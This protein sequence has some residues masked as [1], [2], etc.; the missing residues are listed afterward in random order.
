MVNAMS[1]CTNP[2]E[3]AQVQKE[4]RKLV[5]RAIEEETLW[6]T[7]WTKH[8][9]P[10]TDDETSSRVRKRKSRWGSGGDGSS[11]DAA[12]AANDDDPFVRLARQSAT[13]SSGYDES[14]VYDGASDGT[15]SRSVSPLMWFDSTGKSTRKMMTKKKKKKKKKR[16]QKGKGEKRGKEEG[17]PNLLPV[18]FL[19]A[20]ERARKRQRLQRF[21]ATQGSAHHQSN[22][23]ARR[24]NPQQPVVGTCQRLEKKYFRL[25][26]AVRPC[27]VRPVS[28]LRE[29]LKMVLRKIKEGCD[30]LYACEQFKSMR[31]DL[32][33]QHVQNAFTVE[34]YETHA[35]VAIENS[36][37]NEFNQCQTQLIILYDQGIPSV[38]K[39]EFAAYRILYH[40][41]NSRTISIAQEFRSLIMDRSVCDSSSAVALA[42][43]VRRAVAL[44]DHRAFFK[45]KADAVEISKSGVAKSFASFYA[46]FLPAFRCRAILTMLRAYKPTL[47]IEYVKRELRFGGDVGPSFEAWSESVGIV[48]TDDDRRSIDVRKSKLDGPGFSTAFGGGRLL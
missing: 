26:A 9:F 17:N 37:M 38:A 13:V 42:L 25:T 31:Q 4:L 14:V 33:V 16:K 1:R 11:N 6:T 28:V 29:S 36:D 30:Y 3:K 24:P 35:R 46:A 45:I 41:Y 7:D 21:A 15:T 44:N 10:S 32:T 12:E 2:S 40:V 5:H 22:W 43:R 8:A 18:E 34:V 20:E 27:D 23:N 39:E 19:T 48:L 47:S